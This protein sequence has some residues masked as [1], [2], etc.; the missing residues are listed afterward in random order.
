MKNFLAHN[1]ETRKQLLEVVWHSSIE[2][3]FEHIP[4]KIKSFNLPEALSELETQKNVK[5]LA[6]KN[7]TDYASFIG[8][9]CYNKFIPAAISQVAQR[10]EFLTAYTPYQPEIS[11]GTLQIM[12]E[13]QSMI[14]M[15]TGMEVAN[16]SVYDG[17]SACA[18]AV[19]MACR[20]SKKQ[21][22][23]I[24]NKLNPE[25][26]EVVKTYAHG[27]GIDIQL[28]DVLPENVSD[29]ACVLIQNP[30]FYGEITDIKPV[31]TLL[32]VCTIPACLSVIKPPAAADIVVGDI[33]TLGIP[34]SFGGPHAGFIA[35]KEKYMRQLPGRL[36]G[37]T[38]D[39]E[40]ETAYT[41][42]LQTREQ[43]IRREKATSNI[44]SNQ[45]LIALSATLYL[46]LLGEK[47]FKQTGIL[48]AKYA[49]KLSAELDKIG[50]KTLNK[51]F[52]NEFVI[53]VDNA[54]RVLSELKSNNI[55][56]GLKITE[57]KI[58]VCTTEM[59]TDDEIKQ[60]ISVMCN[61]KFG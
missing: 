24:S 5:K 23:L 18:E 33:Q 34:M 1:E 13:Y 60:Y 41:L 17:G 29:F 36:A 48:S 58:L 42:T 14:C 50:V 16:A 6:L 2:E 45:A 32:I 8:G 31:E 37:K 9:G 56:G 55:L 19:S 53:E 26:M 27:A 3:L 40:G 12:Y 43:H 61:Y 39:A 38:T 11:Q 54:D 59:N 47:G 25:Y 49:H 4:A 20:I 51:N 30:D 28:F 52:F 44:C 10:F 57:N 46:S 15:L 22:A 21:Q 35:C 7:K